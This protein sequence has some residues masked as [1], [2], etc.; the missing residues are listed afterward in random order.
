[1]PLSILYMTTASPRTITL[2]IIDFMQWLIEEKDVK[3]ETAVNY[4]T[5]VR[6]GF[7]THL[8]D[9]SAFDAGSA[10]TLAKTSIKAQSERTER[11]AR[12]AITFEIQPLL[13]EMLEWLRG[14]YWDAGIDSSMIYIAVAFSYNFITRISEVVNVGPYTDSKTGKIKLIDHRPYF[15]ELVL[16]T[17]VG[18]SYKIDTYFNRHPQP[19]I[20]YFRL[21]LISNKTSRRASVNLE[22]YQCYRRGNAQEIQFFDDFMSWV[23]QCGVR[24]LDAPIFS[25]VHPLTGLHAQCQGSSFRNALKSA[26]NAYNIDP[27]Y[28]SGKSTRIGGATNM[29][30]AGRTDADM[31]GL[32][33]HK[34]IAMTMRYA[35]AVSAR[36]NVL[37]NDQSSLPTV[38]Q[39]KRLLVPVNP[40]G[41]T[42]LGWLPVSPDLSSEKGH[43]ILGKRIN[44]GKR[45]AI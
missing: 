3:R 33:G 20:V 5:H 2:G 8:S 9:I 21:E 43:D 37:S 13:P 6:S 12:K 25:R 40:S 34:D 1:M 10:L 24:V 32:A 15:N 45:Q 27:R 31:L 19:M 35:S 30:A 14:H 42:R 39:L 7:I 22:P 26:A 38:D 44:T 4:V 23:H 11:L 16:Q 28:Y 36:G 41:A 18:E 29:R 17:D